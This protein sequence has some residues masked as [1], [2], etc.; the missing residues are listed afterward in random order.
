[1]TAYQ[2]AKDLLPGRGRWD[3]YKYRTK[4]HEKRDYIKR[5]LRQQH[6]K[7]ATHDNNMVATQQDSRTT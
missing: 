4:H 5:D 2:K 1:M 3:K 7:A 6:S